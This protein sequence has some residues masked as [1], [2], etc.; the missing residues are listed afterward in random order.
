MK[1]MNLMNL[2]LGGNP[3]CRLTTVVGMVAVISQIL[4]QYKHGEISEYGLITAICATAFVRLTDEEWVKTLGSK[5]GV[6]NR[7]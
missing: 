3:V 4:E 7:E 1:T 5:I 2:I 6:R